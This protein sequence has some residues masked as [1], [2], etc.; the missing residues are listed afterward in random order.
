MI[1]IHGWACQGGQF[2]D[3]I[4]LL[5]ADVRCYCIDLPGHG[6]TP[7]DDFE[8]GFERYAALI[9]DFA[10]DQKLDRPILLGHS[11]G[12]ILS[13]LAAPSDRL[14]PRA[15]INLDGCLPPAADAIGGLRMIRSWFKEPDFRKRLEA[16][17][18][19]VFFHPSERDARCEAI[20]QTMCSAPEAV[21]RF[22]PEQ[23]DELKSETV[24]A[25]ITCPVLYIGGAEPLFDARQAAAGRAHFRVETIPEA[26]H[27]LQVYAPDRAAG[28]I[29]AFLSDLLP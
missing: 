2:A 20:L 14:H 24:L 15:I 8:P 27:F 16:L 26:G 6:Q 3:L 23:I 19:K 18:R 22:L 21:L 28:L 1:C 9:A 17:L 25:R 29:R 4:R 12:G 7:L 5:A 10:R 11:M 13:L